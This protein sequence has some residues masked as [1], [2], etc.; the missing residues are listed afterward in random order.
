MPGVPDRLPSQFY[1][2][3]LDSISDPIIVINKDY[4]IDYANKSV[5]CG[6]A[7]DSVG[8]KCYTLLHGRKVP[9][10][11]CP[12]MRAFETGESARVIKKSKRNGILVQKELRVYPIF[13]EA[14]RVCRAVEIIQDLPVSSFPSEGA[15]S[16]PPRVEEDASFCG[17]I[18]HSKK[19][20]SLFHMIRL[21]APSHATVLIYGESGTGK[22]RVAQAI[23]RMSN[24]RARPFVAVDCGA[25]PE[26]LLESELFGHV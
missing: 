15:D 13:D 16:N 21:V 7:G 12:S 10:E 6:A 19:M 23:H 4:T 18:G 14:G 5:T 3:I 2:S 11:A 1:H 17:M 8:Q 9:C 24:R 20:Q 25:L 22:E 26:T